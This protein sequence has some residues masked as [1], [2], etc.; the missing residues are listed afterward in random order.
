MGHPCRL[1]LTALRGTRPLHG[2][3]T[4]FVRPLQGLAECRSLRNRG[5]RP[6]IPGL[7]HGYYLSALRAEGC[8]TSRVACDIR[9]KQAAAVHVEE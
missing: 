8:A 6:G 2:T 4:R 9:S 5:R 3:A 7:A 1:R